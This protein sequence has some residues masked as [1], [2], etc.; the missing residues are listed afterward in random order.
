[1]CLFIS[2]LTL[3]GCTCN[4]PT[5]SF[6][7]AVGFLIFL[8]FVYIKTIVF[9]LLLL[10][11]LLFLLFLKTRY[12]IGAL[13]VVDFVFFFLQQFSRCNEIYRSI[14][15]FAAREVSL[16]VVMSISILPVRCTR[17]RCLGSENSFD[18]CYFFLVAAN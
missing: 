2:D 6:I 7:D 8:Y 5:G 4:L 11:V 18:I 15:F 16:Q 3:Y 10:F 9:L 13:C 12:S 17:C 14:E 1:M